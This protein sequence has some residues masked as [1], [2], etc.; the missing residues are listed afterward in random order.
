MNSGQFK[1]VETESRRHFG[2]CQGL[3]DKQEG[4]TTDEYEI[5]FWN[6]KNILK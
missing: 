2:R 1:S 6:D 3:G 5:S 4:I